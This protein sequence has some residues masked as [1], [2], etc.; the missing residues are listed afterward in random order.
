[1]Q[2]LLG[3]RKNRVIVI[4][5]PIIQVV[6]E[7]REPE[8]ATTFNNSQL[9]TPQSRADTELLKAENSEGYS[10]LQGIKNSNVN[11]V[12]S[13]PKGKDPT[14]EPSLSEIAKD[15]VDNTLGPVV[16]DA[17]DAKKAAKKDDGDDEG[18]Y[19]MTEKLFLDIDEEKKQQIIESDGL[20]IP[21]IVDR[22]RFPVKKQ[23]FLVHLRV[24][25][26]LV[27]I[28]A[29]DTLFEESDDES[30]MDKA[31]DSEDEASDRKDTL[32][33][34]DLTKKNDDDGD[35]LLGDGKEEEKFEDD[36]V[37]R[38]TTD[39]LVSDLIRDVLLQ[40]GV[41]DDEALEGQILKVVS[42]HKPEHQLVYLCQLSEKLIN[43]GD[44]LN[45]TEQ[46]EPRI[47]EIEL[48]AA[49]MVQQYLQLL[50]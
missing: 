6:S 28:I 30:E 20:L 35:V 42:L 50:M 24:K 27:K 45:D 33:S 10:D 21:V 38:K 49:K 37:E 12:M 44:C 40:L 7:K 47:K 22:E 1:M 48:Y 46:L 32:G 9:N 26:Q 19:F 41:E 11:S 5:P 25:E 14:L 16:Q 39:H 34:Q 8:D 13:T 23:V 36:G 3:T 18:Q 2:T 15:Y 43:D 17:L 29:S 31:K 4:E